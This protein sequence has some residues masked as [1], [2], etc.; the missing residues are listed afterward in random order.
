MITIIKSLTLLGWLIIAANA[1]WPFG[2]PAHTMLNWTGLALIA[3]HLIETLL[4][5]PLIRRAGGNPVV[6]A[7]K[8]MIFGYG[9]F[10]ALRQQA[11]GTGA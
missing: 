2:E 10:L 6:H 1:L 9:H 5:L 3:A 7:A 8:V 4:Y 11:G